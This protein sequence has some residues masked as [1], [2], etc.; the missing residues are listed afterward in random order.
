MS[1]GAYKTKRIALAR[2]DGVAVLWADLR[3]ALTAAWM[4]IR[5][6]GMDL[7]QIVRDQLAWPPRFSTLFNTRTGFNRAT[8]S[9]KTVARWDLGVCVRV[10]GTP[11]QEIASDRVKYQMTVTT[12]IGSNSSLKTF[13]SAD[14]HRLIDCSRQT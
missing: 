14:L 12:M 10:G 3:H 9:E 13:Q 1:S 11:I 4:T 8:S 2:D 6:G 7:L 5:V